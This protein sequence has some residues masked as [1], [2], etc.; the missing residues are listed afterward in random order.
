VV[1][2]PET[3]ICPLTNFTLKLLAFEGLMPIGVDVHK[4]RMHAAGKI[5]AILAI[6]DKSNG[7]VIKKK[8]R[9]VPPGSLAT[10]EVE[11]LDGPIA[12]EVGDRMV[13]R[14]NGQTVGAGIIIE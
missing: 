8:P 2:S 1:C 4:G 3:A 5:R 7:T 14:L 10:V 6:F 13:L 12:A 11:M 9:H